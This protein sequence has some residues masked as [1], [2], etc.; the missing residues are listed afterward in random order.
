M[1]SLE[2]GTIGGGTKLPGQQACLKMLGIDSSS[3]QIPGENSCQLA[4]LICSTVLAGELSLMS[5]LATND[6]VHS[7]LRLNRSTS[8]LNQIR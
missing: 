7:H 8:G 3:V 5:A 2:V 6:L 1:Y 4:R